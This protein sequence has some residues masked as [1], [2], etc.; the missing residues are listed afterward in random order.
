MSNHTIT[1]SVNGLR[2]N[3]HNEM[4]KLR[5]QIEDMSKVL[6]GDFPLYSI[7]EQQ[8]D[9]KEAF[10]GM[11][12]FVNSFQCMYDSDYKDDFDDQGDKY[13]IELFEVDND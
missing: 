13:E 10:N 9:I 4:E 12:C 11:A 7:E 3:M 6:K 1:V 5:T 2:A 8:R